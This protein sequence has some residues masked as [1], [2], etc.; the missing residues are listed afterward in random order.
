MADLP[1]PNAVFNSLLFEKRSNQFIDTNDKTDLRKQN[2]PRPPCPQ[3]IRNGAISDKNPSHHSTLSIE[4]APSFPN[5]E[6]DIQLLRHQIDN[7]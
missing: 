3:V 1:P 5:M 7:L 6:Q 2:N 4:Q